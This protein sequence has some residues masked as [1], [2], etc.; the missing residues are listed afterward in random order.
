MAR[1][2]AGNTKLTTISPPL[3]IKGGLSRVID[4]A[5]GDYSE[6]DIRIFGK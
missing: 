4:S 1:N 5:T 3:T 2:I 6:D